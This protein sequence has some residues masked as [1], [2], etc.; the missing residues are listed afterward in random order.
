M[1]VRRVP[2]V[3][4]E[5]AISYLA[6]DVFGVVTSVDG[7]GRAVTVRTGNGEQLT[8]RLNGAIARFTENG[9]LT[10]ARLRVLEH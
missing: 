10:G 9:D 7:D 5:V 6:V 4:D 3:G 2:R 8:F 1:H